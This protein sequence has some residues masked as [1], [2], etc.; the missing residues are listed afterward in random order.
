M[1]HANAPSPHLR[2]DETRSKGE[3]SVRACSRK[4]LPV[5]FSS[6]ITVK[7]ASLTVM[8]YICGTAM[9]QKNFDVAVSE[10]AHSVG[11]L[12]R[13]VRSAGASSH[14]LSWTE[15]AVMSRLAKDGPA[16]IADLARAES[17]KPQSMGT[18]IATLEEAGLVERKSHPTDGRQANITLTAKGVAVRKDRRDAK[19]TWLSQA[20]ATL[21]SKDQETLFKA[22]EVI[23]RLVEK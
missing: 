6:I 10:F 2:E 13:R 15:S 21:D 12:V 22:G 14:G 8:F 16:T 7:L 3:A 9:T 20:I 18:T 4:R 11:L 1:A 19:L 5:S 17:V 23:R